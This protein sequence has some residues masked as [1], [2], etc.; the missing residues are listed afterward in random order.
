MH[1]AAN[2]AF[3]VGFESL[4]NGDFNAV[5]DLAT[6]CVADDAS[7]HCM[8]SGAVNSVPP[9][10]R[11]DGYVASKWAAESCLYKAANLGLT[12]QIHHPQSDLTDEKSSGPGVIEFQDDL[13]CCA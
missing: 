1:C 5:K 13:R 8:S 11:G 4:H 12:R 9:V 2:R 3:W 6:L 10:D 7:L